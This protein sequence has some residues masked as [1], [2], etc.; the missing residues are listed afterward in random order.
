MGDLGDRIKRY[1]R[2]STHVLVRRM[3]VII[4]VDGRCF[5]SFT[6]CCQRPFDQEIINAMTMAALSLF[7]DIQGTKLAYAQSD[8]VSFLLVDY[9]RHES[10]S[11]FDNELTKIVSISASHMAVQVMKYFVTY[12]TGSVHNP[13]IAAKMV[14]Q[15]DS[16][17]FNVPREDVA[18]YFLWRAQDWQRNSLQMYARSFFSHKEL[19]NQ[20]T[21]DMHE[22]LHGIGKNWATDL[23]LQQ[24][25]GTWLID[26]GN[27]IRYRH[28]ILPVFED[29]N[30][31]VD[32]LVNPKKEE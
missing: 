28:D 21:D 24:K 7:E 5:S 9:D 6:R 11:W 15:F 22:M 3:P 31:I 13:V 27:G 26:D 19:M 10:E 8:E 14:P 32:P 23:T 12:E 2:A 29:I 4:R 16:R 20:K 25:N 17:A 1:E 30:T 18:N